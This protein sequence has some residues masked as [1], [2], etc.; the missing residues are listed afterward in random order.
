LKAI[1]HRAAVP[2][3]ALLLIAV[4]VSYLWGWGAGIAI[5]GGLIWI[6]LAVGSRAR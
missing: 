6:D 4:G 5:V 1:F 3:S 2:L